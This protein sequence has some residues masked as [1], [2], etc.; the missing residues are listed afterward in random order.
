M[1]FKTYSIK[2]ADCKAQKQWLV[3]DA[4]GAS[5]GRLAVE[6]ARILRGKHKAIFTP[7]MDCG[8]NVIVVNARHVGLSG[9]K[10]ARKDGKM[11]YWHTGYPGGIKETTAG[12]LLEGRYPERVI[13]LAVKRMITDNAL[14]KTQ[15]K[16]LYIYPEQDHPHAAQNP[17]LHDFA[18][19]NSKNLI[20]S[21]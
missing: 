6:I 2:E 21:S 3:I 20:R 1:Y 17:V 12:K 18:S 5:L 13:E 19:K 16:H 14:R 10:K 15:M 9:N 8:D 11:Y 7:H 4:K